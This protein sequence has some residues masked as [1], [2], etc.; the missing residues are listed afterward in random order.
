MPGYV[1]DLITDYTLQWLEQ[2]GKDKPFMLMCHH[3]APHD[4][5]EYHPKYVQLYENI[6]II[7]P[8]TFEESFPVNGKQFLAACLSS[9][10]KYLSKVAWSHTGFTMEQVRKIMRIDIAKLITNVAYG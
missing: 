4:K 3:K 2:R 8:E 5:F 10:T 7:E 9:F 1:T 6:D